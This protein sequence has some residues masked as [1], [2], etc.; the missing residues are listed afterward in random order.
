MIFNEETFFDGKPTK[1][2]I[3]LITALNKTINL[4]EVQPALNFEDIQ[5]G[6]DEKL[7]TDILQ[8]LI[9]IDSF[10]DD[11]KDKKLLNKLLNEGFYFILPLSV[12]FL[13]YKNVFI[14]VR[15]KGIKKEVLAAT[16]ITA[17]T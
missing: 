13:D 2:I 10:K 6:E 16:P 17:V 9:D 4:I 15:S 7:P 3:E 1:I 5:L 8:D 14:F 11:I 12:Y